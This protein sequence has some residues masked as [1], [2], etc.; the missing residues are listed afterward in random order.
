MD[1]HEFEYRQ[2]IAFINRENE[3][4]YLWNFV[5]KRPA[6]ILF[7]HGPKSSGKTTLLYKFLEQVGKEKKLDVKFLNLREKF[8]GNYKDFI[9][10]FFGIDYDSSKGE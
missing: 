9:H 6:E 1:K 5:D 2:D 4:Q 8:I 7:L 3:L 10:V